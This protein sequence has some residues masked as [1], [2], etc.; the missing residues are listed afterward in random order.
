MIIYLIVINEK[1]Y[2]Y[3]NCIFGEYSKFEYRRVCVPVL[4]IL[5]FLVLVQGLT[6][7]RFELN[8]LMHLFAGDIE[9]HLAFF[10]LVCR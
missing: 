10:F 2:N 5:L 7:Y 1:I 8:I 6:K 4:H 9:I 3:L